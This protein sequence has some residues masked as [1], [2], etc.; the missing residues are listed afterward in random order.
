MERK[1][2]FTGKGDALRGDIVLPSLLYEATHAVVLAEQ[3]ARAQADVVRETGSQ[4]EASSSGLP[5]APVPVVQKVLTPTSPDD[6]SDTPEAVSV[7]SEMAAADPVV[8]VSVPPLP[9]LPEGEPGSLLMRFLAAV[10]T[11]ETPEAHQVLAQVLRLVQVIARV[12]GAL[13]DLADRFRVHEEYRGRRMAAKLDTDSQLHETRIRRAAARQ[14]LEQWEA[15]HPLRMWAA[16]AAGSEDG[17]PMEW[18][19]LHRE[20]TTLDRRVQEIKNVLRRHRGHLDDFDL[21]AQA[22]EGQ[23]AEQK[24][25]LRQTMGDVQALAP[26]LTDTLVSVAKEEERS[27]IEAVRPASPLL[28]T[29]QSE[30]VPSLQPRPSIRSR[31]NP[32]H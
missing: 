29:T 17:K 7:S 12:L 21:E 10:P 25:L 6:R 9:P 3:Q 26:T 1:G 18:R 28:P 19:A 24:E 4:Q 8:P 13:A 16:K 22:L 14:R 2:F 30:D 27:W 32:H 23:Q 11:P 15:A 5:P 20:A 31:V